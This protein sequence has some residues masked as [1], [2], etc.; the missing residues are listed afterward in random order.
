MASKN[1]ELEIGSKLRIC[2][3]N[4][5]GISKSKCDILSKLGYEE[6]VQVFSVTR[7]PYI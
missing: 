7:N 5:E 3:L 2:S 6:N 1:N 4:I